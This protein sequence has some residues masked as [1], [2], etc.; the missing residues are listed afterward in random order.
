MHANTHHYVNKSRPATVGCRPCWDRVVTPCG[1]YLPMSA[2]GGRWSHHTTL[3][4]DVH[5]YVHNVTHRYGWFSLFFSA[6]YWYFVYIS[7]DLLGPLRL[8][9]VP[10]SRLHL[11]RIFFHNRFLSSV[12]HKAICRLRHNGPLSMSVHPPFLHIVCRYS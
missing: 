6:V 3:S 1:S 2:G 12:S 10:E 4:T 8:R 9:I 11:H 5:I 7:I